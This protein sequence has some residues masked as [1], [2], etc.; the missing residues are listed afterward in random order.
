MPKYK[1]SKSKKENQS[2]EDTK[3]ESP[4]KHPKNL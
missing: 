3:N 2:D 4:N 1:R